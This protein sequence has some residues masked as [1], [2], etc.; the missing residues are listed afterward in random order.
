MVVSI[1]PSKSIRGTQPPEY[2]MKPYTSLK[3]ILA[4]FFPLHRTLASDDHDKTLEIVGSYMPDSSNYT[5][6]TYAPLTPVW[7]WKVPERY[8]VH[9]AYLETEDG[10]R[11]VDFKDNPLHIV[12][13]SLP[14]D[15]MLTFEE[16]QPHLYFNEKRPHTVPWVFKYYERDWGFCLPKKAF[17]KLPR[18]KKYHAVINC[19]FV[20]DPK[21]GFKVATAVVH[22]QGGPHPAHGAYPEVGEF[23]VQAHTCHPMQANDDGAGV[24]STIELARRLAENP[25]PAGSMSVRFWFGPETIGT[26]AWLAHNESLIPNL[27][28]GIFMEM[29]GNQNQIAWHHTRQH[30]HLLD[31][32][33]NYVLRDTPH[34][35]RDFAAAP[36]NDERVI[37]G[38]G[39]NV[40]CISLNRFPYDEYHT[41]D[42]NLDIMHEDMLLGAART[43]EEIIRIYASNYTPRRTFRG[44]VF[45]SGHGLWVDWRD[46]WALN[47]AIEKLMMRFEG[48]HSIFD[49]AEQ[50]GLE[51]ET[52][53]EYVEKFRAKGFV[54]PL[55]IPSE[56]QAE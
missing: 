35:E 41:T 52:V 8:V 14:T 15:K 23:L 10:E 56:A 50:V 17:D 32:I 12:S 39:V 51:Y 13:Y 20:T 2:L 55:P 9:E 30:D 37:N 16:L 53:R 24:V 27:R 3:S 36:A 33:T 1:R 48:E 5:I 19:E 40:P 26:I 43:A 47:R 54:V 22:P 28:G 44:P 11:I 25:L 42:D 31:R 49:I 34:D 7:T 21:Q 45:L 46:N 6:E 4:E 38:P 18:D 29:T